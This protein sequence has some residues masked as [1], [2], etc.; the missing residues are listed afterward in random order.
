[1]IRF[2]FICHGMMLFVERSGHIEI[3]LPKIDEHD[4]KQGQPD[5]EDDLLTIEEGESWELT[6]PTSGSQKM[7]DLISTR[8]HLCLSARKFEAVPG[9]AR[10]AVKIPIPDRVRGYRPVEVDA[11]LFGKGSKPSDAMA[12][13]LLLHDVICFSY[14]SYDKVR[15]T[16]SKG[17]RVAVPLGEL[18][19]SWCLYSQPTR[20]ERVHDIGNMNAL[21]RRR[22]NQAAPDFRLARP[23]AADKAP[24]PAKLKGF[25]RTH[26]LN[27][28]EI[29]N[30]IFSGE[31][32]PGGC[33][34]D[35]LLG[36]GGG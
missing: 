13:P 1:M 35:F 6:G 32:E 25:S 9:N 4:Y 8:D 19:G 36:G 5:R 18:G 2:N 29:N 7:S 23:L 21:L 20:F 31:T 10:N 17:K 34:G 16:S 30:P 27:L 12:Q 14:L 11:S 22:S 24:H 26:L 28:Y 33:S 15:L 3:L